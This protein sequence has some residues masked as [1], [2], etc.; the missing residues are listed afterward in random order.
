MLHNPS[1]PPAGGFT[2]FE[3]LAALGLCALLAA[4]TASAIAFA[5]RAERIAARRAEATL[6]IPNLYASQRLRPDDLPEVPRPWQIEQPSEFRTLPDDSLCEW[7]RIRLTVAGNEIPPL[8][9]AI[10]ND[11][12]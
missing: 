2:L 1:S 3:V 8:A 4:T 10:L 11:A 12:P 5:G 9:L 6:L 7:N